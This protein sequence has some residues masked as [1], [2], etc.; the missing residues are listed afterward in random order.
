V[1]AQGKRATKVKKVKKPISKAPKKQPLKI[2]EKK[3]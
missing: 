3:R 1:P 2:E